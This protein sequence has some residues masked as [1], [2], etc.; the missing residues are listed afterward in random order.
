MSV[1]Y[2]Y[3]SFQKYKQKY[4]SSD[5]ESGTDPMG[6]GSAHDG[7]SLMANQDEH[8]DVVQVDL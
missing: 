5:G 2:A 8:D 6:R 4:M 7:R 3:D 1:K